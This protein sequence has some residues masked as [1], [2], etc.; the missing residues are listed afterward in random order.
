VAHFVIQRQEA[1]TSCDEP[2]P[3]RLG[4]NPEHYS[5]EP[6]QRADAIRAGKRGY[7]CPGGETH[8][9]PVWIVYDEDNDRASNAGAFDTFREAKDLRDRLNG[10]FLV[11]DPATLRPEVIA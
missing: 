10:R 6:W 3:I 5:G 11:V 1:E 9:Y 4:R 8:L 7:L 2:H